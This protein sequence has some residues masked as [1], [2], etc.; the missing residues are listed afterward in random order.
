MKRRPVMALE[1]DGVTVEVYLLNVGET[2]EGFGGSS[3]GLCVRKTASLITRV[4]RAM[5]TDDVEWDLASEKAW[6]WIN[7]LPMQYGFRHAKQITEEE[8]SDVQV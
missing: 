3:R 4:K 8:S 2:F 1:K 6:A 7:S 5:G